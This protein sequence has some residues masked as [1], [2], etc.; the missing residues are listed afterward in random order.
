[1]Y[2]NASSG[3]EDDFYRPL[4]IEEL[5]EEDEITPEEEGFMFGWLAADDEEAVE[6]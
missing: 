4:L 3:S 6:E 1:M 5:Q 2:E